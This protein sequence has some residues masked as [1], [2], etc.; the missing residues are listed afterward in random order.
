MAGRDQPS[1]VGLAAV[2]SALGVARKPASQIDGI[3]R[4]I[5]KLG[6]RSPCEGAGAIALSRPQQPGE[7]A[8]QA[9]LVGG[10]GAGADLQRLLEERAGAGIVELGGEQ[11]ALR[12][13]RGEAALV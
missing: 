1:G 5:L 12:Q 10:G 8:L 2:R 13:G 7:R 3:G 4:A 6:E 9:W 11:G